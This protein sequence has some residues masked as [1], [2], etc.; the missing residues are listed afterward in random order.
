[1]QANLATH[2]VNGDLPTVSSLQLKQKLGL[3]NENE[4]VYDIGLDCMCI[5]QRM[6]LF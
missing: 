4:F 3:S 5:R 1:M 2:V 6:L